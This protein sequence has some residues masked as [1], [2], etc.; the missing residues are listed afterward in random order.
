MASEP[1][2]AFLLLGLGYDVLSVAPPALPLI[3]WMVRQVRIGDART[4]AEACLAARTAADVM[5]ILRESLAVAVD[6][7]LLDPDAPLPARRR[8]ASLNP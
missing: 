8:S 7:K 4:A 6:L 1:L 2:S 3:K 5:T